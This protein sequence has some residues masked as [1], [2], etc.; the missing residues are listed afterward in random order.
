MH[1]HLNVQI[2]Q[3]MGISYSVTSQ[4]TGILLS[5]AQQYTKRFHKVEFL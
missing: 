4:K 1:S 5:E 2:L 3:H